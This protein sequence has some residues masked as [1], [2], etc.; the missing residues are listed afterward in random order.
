MTDEPCS[1]VL[2]TGCCDGWDDLDPDLQ[3]Q[4]TRY[5]TLVLWSATGRRYGECEHTV[6]PCGRYCGEGYG[7]IYAD[8]FWT[9]YIWNGVW[10][11]CWC[12][13]GPGCWK[14][15]PDCQLYLPGPVASVTEVLLDGVVV[16]PDTYRVWA[17]GELLACEPAKVLPMAQRYFLF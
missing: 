12:G 9:P 16:D 10:R 17:D 11:N 3:A 8:G 13:E 6:R 7:Y 5:A 14:C 15:K 2:G 4:A 1:W